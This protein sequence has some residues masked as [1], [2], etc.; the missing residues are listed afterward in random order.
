MIYFLIV[1]IVW[2]G[3]LQPF[4]FAVFSDQQSA[5]AAMQALNVR[6]L[7][8]LY[9]ET[10]FQSRNFLKLNSYSNLF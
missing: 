8:L 1:D 5:I 7:M 6:T 2:M 10:V 9:L 4:A 3:L